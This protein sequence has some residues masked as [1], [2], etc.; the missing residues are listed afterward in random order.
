MFWAKVK[1]PHVAALVTTAAM[2]AVAG[3]AMAQPVEIQGMASMA[4]SGSGHVDDK[5]RQQVLKLAEA[6]AMNRYSAS[7]S[8]SQFKLY[9]GAEKNILD[10][11]GDYLA[12]PTVVEDGIKKDSGQYYM[13]IR[14]TV[15]T[16]RLDAALAPGSGGGAA[17]S[18]APSRKITISFLFAARAATS[19]KQFDARVTKVVAGQTEGKAQQTQKLSGGTGSLTSSTSGSAQITVGGNTVRQA[20]QEAYDVSSPEDVNAA[21]SQ[22][23][24]DSGFESYDYRDVNAQCGGAKPE[25]LY[26]AFSTSDSLSADL[27]RSVFDAAKKCQ[28]NTFATGTLDMGLQDTDPV[29][30]QKRVYVSVRMQVNDLSGA[31]PRLLASVGPV[32]YSGTGPSQDVAGRNAL[33]N[34]ATSAA[35]EIS[36]QLKS[37][38]MN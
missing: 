17:A 7:F 1:L 16:N 21:M 30:G 23:F 32:Q 3:A 8:P 2:M 37:K 6:D 4:Y 25:M 20:D 29:T 13:V 12:Q 33:I 35:K 24:S 34:A 26:S 15:N 27:R 10:N 36:S 14:T 31:L 5:T 11:I 28:V 19:V 22:V 9:Q 38:G 18:V